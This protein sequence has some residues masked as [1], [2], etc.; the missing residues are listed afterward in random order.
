MKTNFRYAVSM[1]ALCA[2]I[3]LAPVV[4]SAP[5]FAAESGMISRVEVQGTERIDPATVLSYMTVKPGDSYTQESLSESTKAIYG[6]GLFADVNIQPQGGVLVVKVVENPLINQI[7]FE[8]NDELKDEEL[9]AEVASRPRNVLARNTVLSDV[10]RLQEV[11]RRQGRFSVAIE[12]KVIRLDQNR[13]N[14][15]FEVAEGPK[16]EIRGVKF[17]GNSEFS[18]DSL[19]EV[20]ASK[21]SRWYRFLSTSDSYDGDRLAYDQELLRRFYLREGYVDF[22]VV[23]AVAELTPDK[24]SFFVTFTVEEGERYKVGNVSVDATALKGADPKKLE[25]EVAFKSGDWYNADD[26]QD[27]VEKMTDTLGDMQYA[28]V[29]VSPDVQRHEDTH[30]VDVVYRMANTPKVYVE[31]IDIKGNVRTQDKVIRR[32]FE[33]AEG[34]AFN[35]TKIAKAEQDLKD[36]DFFENV[37]VRPVQGSAP[38]QS[39]VQV[40]VE[41]KSTGEISLGAGFSTTDGPL[42]DFGIRER[43]FLGKG[44]DLSFSTAISGR[45]SE[46]DLSFTEPYFLDRDL[47]AGVDAFHTTRDLQSESSYDQ[48]RTGGALRLGFPL[49]SHLRETVKYRLENNRI[50]NV[51]ADASRFIRDQEGTRMTS[52][53]SQRLVYDTRD[54]TMFPTRGLI[55]WFDTE[56]AGLGGDAQYV[57]GKL[58]ANAYFPIAKEWILSGL[59]EGGAIEGWGDET[60]RINERYSLGGNNLRGFSTSGIGPRDLTSDDALGGNMFY[61]GSAEL[62]FPVGLP[63]ELGVRGHAFTDFGSLWSV[64]DDGASI[65]DEQSVRAAGGLGVS[66][67]SPFGPIRLDY[68]EPYVKEDY[69]EVEKFRFSF[70]T[71]F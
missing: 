17:V 7:A 66:W 40:D 9:M 55:G 19:R 54:S 12:P 6:T 61:R 42:A 41:E 1:A 26:L 15:V 43:N 50:E 29:A 33:L 45:K 48:K 38:D 53:M 62:S 63:E 24:E 49:S 31:R 47:S 67:R 34:D 56:V 37:K 64:D 70:G 51:D 8:G 57:S 69:D 28:F 44:Q 10:E 20:I 21:E 2:M 52:A 23:S 32:E 3:S 14:L 27:S 46:F 4:S 35:K 36:L 18:D 59:V 22:R 5:A 16:S 39:V 30:T 71:H 13:V 25:S 68:S 11:Y 60:V 65:V 58:G